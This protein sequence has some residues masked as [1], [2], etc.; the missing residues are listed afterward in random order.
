[1]RVPTPT[2]NDLGGQLLGIRR[3]FFSGLS[4]ARSVIFMLGRYLGLC[5]A[6]CLA[7]QHTLW[8]AP[9]L[10]ESPHS[11]TDI[12]PRLIKLLATENNLSPEDALLH[13]RSTITQ[14]SSGKPYYHINRSDLTYWFYGEFQMPE[15]FQPQLMRI[16]VDHPYPQLD[17]VDLYQMEND[18]VTNHF[19][20]GVNL[21]LS[22]R[23]TKSRLLSFEVPLKPNQTFKFLVKVRS[24]AK[25]PFRLSVQSVSSYATSTAEYELVW[26]LFFGVFV[27]A[28][29]INFLIYMAIKDKV[30]LLYVAFV[31]ANGIT[32]ACL[33]NH[34]S[35][36]FWPEAPG[37]NEGSNLFFL[38]FTGIAG[39]LFTQ[40]FLKL[41][42]HA[43]RL[44]KLF[45]FLLPLLAM[46]TLL[47]L[48]VRYE[49]AVLYSD[50]VMGITTLM[51]ITAGI[52]AYRAGVRS[53]RFFMLGWGLLSV[54]VIVYILMMRS[55]IP[56]NQI[57]VFSLQ[58]GCVAEI[59]I[60]AIALGDK[61]RF[62]EQERKLTFQDQKDTLKRLKE[63]ESRLIHKALHDSNSGLPNRQMLVSRIEQAIASISSFDK[64]YL[65]LIKIKGLRDINNT[66]GHFI[67]DKVAHEVSNHIIKLISNMDTQVRIDLSNGAEEFLAVTQGMTFSFVFYCPN[68]QTATSLLGNLL[69][70][71]PQQISLDGLALDTST[72][73]GLC[74]MAK[75]E[76][77]PELL[78]RNAFVAIELAEKNN[79]SCQL[80]TEAVN[81]YSERRLTLISD[82]KK[83]LK[84]NELEVYLQPQLDT[85]NQCVVSAEALLRWKHPKLGPIRPDE[86]IEIAENSGSITELTR[87]VIKN[88]IAALESLH[89]DKKF[90]GLSINISAKNMQEIDLT[91][92]IVRSLTQAHISPEYI[93]L[94]ITETAMMQNPSEIHYR[95]SQWNELGLATSIDDFGTGYSSLSHLKKY[96][97]R[98]LK[99]DRSF[100]KD[101]AINDD[102]LMIVRSTL[103]ISHNMRMRVVAEG[104][105]DEHLL[106]ML[107]EMGCDIIQ[108]YLLTPPLP[109]NEFKQWL[110]HCKYKVG[111]PT[112][113]GV[114]RI[115]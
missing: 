100:V 83:A 65:S 67:G 68:D 20:N 62:D 15:D 24:Q 112:P 37:W 25:Q 10:I 61:I 14:T 76:C 7:F 34:A 47:S 40:S 105:E 56:L 48:T 91:D 102:D 115:H 80:Y 90:I 82:L 51:T 3:F 45:I 103:D 29:V 22:A 1:M 94:E 72:C 32:Q 79:Q 12:T 33:S 57:T 70:N 106:S 18:T 11:Q 13:L 99:I 42:T 81:P 87:W 43:P 31:V 95:L 58:L 26:G 6:L 19:K 78:I 4:A 85:K 8:A 30:Y 89:A 50:I 38:G 16:N 64:I 75:K 9:V 39:I 54:C 23:Q 46:I 71:L 108:G 5:L 27:I 69:G 55:M 36:I 41:K 86:F 109:L 21:P 92:F 44:N 93:T 96:P 97:M 74:G 101:M 59:I 66:L 17:F 63:A 107:S 52:V 49:T 110:N 104:V 53:A 77:N 111:Y 2:L 73:S 84:N 88:S 28:A 60:I 113:S 114:R 35:Y 98:E